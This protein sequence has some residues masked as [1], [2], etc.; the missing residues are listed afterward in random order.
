M[1][2]HLRDNTKVAIATMCIDVGLLYVASSDRLHWFDNGFV[3]VVLC[4]HILFYYALY[5]HDNRL[6]QYLHYLIFVML[7]VSIFLKNKKLMIVC[8]GVLLTI[9][10]LWIVED[11]CI[12]NTPDTVKFGFN[13]ELSVAVL[14]YTV[15]LSMKIAGG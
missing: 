2:E 5:F 9:Q 8:L 4:S 15:M 11:R 13:K 14:L 1:I 12:L 7:A 10:I 3:S 6:I